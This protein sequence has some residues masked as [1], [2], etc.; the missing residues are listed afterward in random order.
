MAFEKHYT[1]RQAAEAV[2]KKAQEVL[3]KSELVKAEPPKHPHEQDAT[4]PRGPEKQIDPQ[5][6][7]KEHAE[8]NNELAGTT[9]TQVGQDGK[10][11]PGFDE[12]KGHL[13][14]AKFIGHMEAR[15]KGRAKPAAV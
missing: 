4:G 2:L 12:M 7:P 5:H 1:A 6:N 13:K 11:L 3:S 15:R 9:P 8:G 10:N 14:L